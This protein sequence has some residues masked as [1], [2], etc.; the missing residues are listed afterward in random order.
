MLAATAELPIYPAH[1]AF[2]ENMLLTQ[3]YPSA[4]LTTR[5]KIYRQHSIDNRDLH[6]WCGQGSLRLFC[7][8]E[9]GF[10]LGISGTSRRDASLWSVTH[11]RRQL[12]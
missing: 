12:L 3:Q 11:T 1:D 8:C 2:Q 6:G 5:V 4:V 7:V 9:V 10:R